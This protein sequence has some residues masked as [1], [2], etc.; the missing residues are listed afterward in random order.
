MQLKKR[1]GKEHTDILKYAINLSMLLVYNVLS[2]E[3]NPLSGDVVENF[4][5]S[6][7][8]ICGLLPVSLLDSE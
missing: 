6:L 1:R 5:L 2:S 7:M 8:H 4:V 3:A